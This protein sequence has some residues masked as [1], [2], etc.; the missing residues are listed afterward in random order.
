MSYLAGWRNGQ[1]RLPES[2]I[3][4]PISEHIRTHL[5]AVTDALEYTPVR[6]G[7]SGSV[8]SF[9]LNSN[10]LLTLSAVRRRETVRAGQG[11]KGLRFLAFLVCRMLTYL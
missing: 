3:A 7:H 10:G 11:T 5:G 4:S 8:P 1:R 9:H 2:G 6:V